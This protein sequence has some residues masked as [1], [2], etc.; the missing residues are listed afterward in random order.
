MRACLCV[1]LILAAS[2]A[3]AQTK[4]G[5]PRSEDP[6]AACIRETEKA[7]PP[8]TLSRKLRDRLV[9]DCVARRPR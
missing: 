4:S 8:R 5:K 6:R 3:A 1:V 2:A 7:H 9:E